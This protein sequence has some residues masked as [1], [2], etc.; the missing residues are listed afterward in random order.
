MMSILDS[1]PKQARYLQKTLQI[2]YYWKSKAASL[3]TIS[4]RLGDI[5]NRKTKP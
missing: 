3:E 2:D 1:V 4:R 5:E